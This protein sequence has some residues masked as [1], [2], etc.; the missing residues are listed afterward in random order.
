[1]IKPRSFFA[2][3]SVA[4]LLAAGDARAAFTYA[5]TATTTPTPPATGTAGTVTF[6]QSTY[7]VNPQSQ[8]PVPPFTGSQIINIAQPVQT[9]TR[10][11]GTDTTSFTTNLAVTITNVPS[12]LSN[13]INVTGRIDVT[14]SDTTGAIS[15]FTLTSILPTSITLDGFTYSLSN[16]T[17]AAPTIGTTSSNGA[18]SITI[19]ETVVPEPASLV[20]MG[21]SVLALGGLSVLRRRRQ[22]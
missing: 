16:P 8:A 4:L 11:V 1:M 14:R 20:M 5:T 18:I 22:S 17:Y 13:T 19:T 15:S 9:S 3:L 10:T 12:G 7:A 6:G 21:T 2:V